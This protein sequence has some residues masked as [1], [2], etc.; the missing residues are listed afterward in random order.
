MRMRS[1]GIVAAAV[2]ALTPTLSE[3]Q[4]NLGPTV[5][6][7]DD[8]DFGIGATLTAPL[9]AFEVGERTTFVAD[10]IFF[11]PTATGVDYFEVNGNLRRDFPLAGST[12]MPFVLAGINFA[13]QTNPVFGTGSKVGV[14]L[15]GGVEL[16]AGTLRP[17][18]GGKIE[19]G[20]G[21]GLMIFASLPFQLGG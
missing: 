4:V 13:R 21:E 2:L 17:V 19:I 18:I 16:D 1:S 9:T 8:A 15:G 5:A 6:F 3:A 12:V 10:F 14:N 20:G 11:F 7:H